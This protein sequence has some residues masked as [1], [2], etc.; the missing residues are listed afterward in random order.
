MIAHGLPCRTEPAAFISSL[1]LVP[2][3]LNIM[4]KIAGGLRLSQCVVW[5][6]LEPTMPL[7]NV[8]PGQQSRSITH[9]PLHI[10]SYSHRDTRVADQG[11]R[12]AR[13]ALRSSCN[14]PSHRVSSTACP[15]LSSRV[16]W[17][18]NV[19]HNR[20]PIRLR[21]GGSADSHCLKCLSKSLFQVPG[22]H[23]SVILVDEEETTLA[24]DCEHPAI[25]QPRARR[26]QAI[27]AMWRLWA[28]AVESRAKPSMERLYYETR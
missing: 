16:F 4:G 27:H 21:H 13:T 17:Q 7:K 5:L 12:E 11:L 10:S 1:D 9:V 8:L 2:L 28:D 19:P 20:S 22:S 18:T 3:E 14:L 15:C 25:D 24:E 23:S 26:I 6:L